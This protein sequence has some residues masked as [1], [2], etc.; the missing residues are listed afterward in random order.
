ML[1]FVKAAVRIFLFFVF[2]IEVIDNKKALTDTGAILAVNHRSNWDPVIAAIATP[3]IIRFMA[4]SE[5]FKNK[6]FGAL[7]TKLGAFPV[8]RGKGDI[9]A[10]KTSMRML[11][12]GQMLLIF[13]EGRRVKAG[14]GSAA[15]TGAVMIAHRSEVP[16]IPVYIS[17]EYKW[18][19]KITVKF[20]EPISYREFYGQKL[21][22]EELQELSNKLLETMKSLRV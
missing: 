11:R 4:K 9:S 10:I 20:G 6:L 1:K 19:R 18:M 12:D 22:R 8:E 15:K 21:S 14:E 7:I 13:P 3:R 2:R 16:I 5:L 17:G